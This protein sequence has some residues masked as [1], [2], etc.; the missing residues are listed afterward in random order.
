QMIESEWPPG[1]YPIEHSSVQTIDAH[2]NQIGNRR[3]F[4]ETAKA[5]VLVDFENA[6]VDFL[7]PGGGGNGEQR[8]RIRV[9]TNEL[10]IVEIGQN[11][12]IE[13][14]KVVGKIG[15]ELQRSHCAERLGLQRI[16]NANLPLVAVGEIGAQDFRLVI[17]GE[18][19][20]LDALG[21]EL[22][23]DDFEDRL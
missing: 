19:D 5:L 18:R 4:V 21:C 22:S 10:C 16:I 7:S 8:A 11:I 1:R 6:K 2:A 12:A 17:H 20:V 9:G 14:Q 3:L 15:N 23:N 13:H